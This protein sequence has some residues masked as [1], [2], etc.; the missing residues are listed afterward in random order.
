MTDLTHKPSERFVRSAL[1]FLKFLCL[2][3]LLLP[4]DP[5]PAANIHF[6]STD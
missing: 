4:I 3:K 2:L 5:N 6:V 1:S